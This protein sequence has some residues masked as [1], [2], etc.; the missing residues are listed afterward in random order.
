MAESG[1]PMPEVKQEHLQ[2]LISQGYMIATELATCRVPE[3]P[4]SPAPAGGYIVVSAAFYERGFGV[5]L[6]RF[7]HLLLQFYGLG[8]ASFDSFGDPEDVTRREARRVCSER[9][10]V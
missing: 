4:A 5:P 8:A 3:D 2:N 6:H 10:W 1:W 7:L 9:L